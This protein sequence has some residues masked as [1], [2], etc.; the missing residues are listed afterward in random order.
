VK[1]YRCIIVMPEK[2]SKEK[3]KKFIWIEFFFFVKY[4][5]V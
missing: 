3:V 5:I 4:F 1:N 2:M